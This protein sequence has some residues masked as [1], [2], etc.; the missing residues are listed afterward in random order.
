MSPFELASIHFAL[1]QTGDGFQ[2]LAKA[3]QDRC[4]E[5]ICLRVDPRWQSLRGNPRYRELFG[6]MGLP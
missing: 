1:D 5:L 4:F 2:W 6:Q 3:F